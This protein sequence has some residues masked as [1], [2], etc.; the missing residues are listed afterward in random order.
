MFSQ[1][2]NVT[3]EVVQHRSEAQHSSDWYD[4]F[5]FLMK[6]TSVHYLKLTALNSL[7]CLTS[8]H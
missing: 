3:E 5:S 8:C 2:S 1:A 7:L 4:A 6:N